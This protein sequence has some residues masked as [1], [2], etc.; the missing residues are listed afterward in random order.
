MGPLALTDRIKFRI[1]FPPQNPFVRC[2]IS[3]PDSDALNRWPI[4]RV[5]HCGSLASWFAKKVKASHLQIAVANTWWSPSSLPTW[6]NKEFYVQKIQP[7][8]R[9]VKVREIAQAMQVSQAYATFIRSGQRSPH[10]R[11]WLVLAQLVK[12][13]SR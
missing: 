13:C 12:I 7:Q 2:S 3:P 1:S 5:R 6:L 4:R 10:P 11:H 9:T 8:L